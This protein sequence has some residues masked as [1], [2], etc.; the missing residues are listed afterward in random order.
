VSIALTTLGH[1]E[2]VIEFCKRALS[3]EEN[4]AREKIRVLILMAYAL[5]SRGDLDTTIEILQRV[6]EECEEG[7][8]LK[9]MAIAYGNLGV[10]YQK[11]GE[12]TKAEKM[13][14]K[15]LAIN[16]KLGYK[17]GIVCEYT[18]L[19]ILYTGREDFKRAEHMLEK[20]QETM[21]KVDRH[22]ICATYVNLGL[23][24]KKK[25]PEGNKRA[26]NMF[27]KALERYE[28]MGDVE[29]KAA[30]CFNLGTVLCVQGELQEA[31]N[32]L[33]KSLKYYEAIGNKKMCSEVI[34]ILRPICHVNKKIVDSAEKHTILNEILRYAQ[35]VS[36]GV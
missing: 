15:A 8:Y 32:M 10:T 29:G 27:R 11:K 28:T 7:E 5:D 31:E 16:K 3:F 36:K 25:G 4:K 9:S 26:E 33:E 1:F 12:G 22:I 17:K 35:N 23:M 20:A 30:C 14:K 34:S 21:K 2:A 13:H 6:I 24:W 19:S 18:N